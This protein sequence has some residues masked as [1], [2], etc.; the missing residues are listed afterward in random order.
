MGGHY[1][2]G[3]GAAAQIGFGNVT[4]MI[5]SNIFPI[6]Q[7]PYFKAEYGNCLALI[8]LTVVATTVMAIYE[9]GK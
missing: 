7:A 4:G 3:I 8:L 6:F 2:K 1:K 9:T 5:A